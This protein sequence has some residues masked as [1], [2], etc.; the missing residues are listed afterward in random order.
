MGFLCTFKVVA[1]R[2]NGVFVVFAIFELCLVRGGL[3]MVVHS[4][5]WFVIAL[6]FFKKD[7]G[8]KSP[9]RAYFVAVF[10]EQ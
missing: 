1:G 10:G 5:L 9:S 2:R 8:S 4:L 6:F 7:C 3:F